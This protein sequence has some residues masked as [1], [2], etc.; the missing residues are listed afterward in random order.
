MGG[1][2]DYS[3]CHVLEAPIKLTTSVTASRG[4]ADSDCFVVASSGFGEQ[5]VPLSLLQ[6]SDDAN[7]GSASDSI[8]SSSRMA[9]LES[10]GVALR[11]E[12]SIASWACYAIGELFRIQSLPACGHLVFSRSVVP[13]LPLSMLGKVP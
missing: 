13:S 4:G 9:S 8:S 5:R 3:G 2:A 10:I 6:A 12:S 7:A 1:V 11:A